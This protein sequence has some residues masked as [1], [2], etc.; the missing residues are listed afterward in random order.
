[1]N[2]HARIQ[3]SARGGGHGPPAP[4]IRACESLKPILS[5]RR[6]RARVLTAG[7]PDGAVGEGW[8]RPGRHRSPRS[9]PRPP[10]WTNQRHARTFRATAPRLTLSALPLPK[11]N[12]PR[13]L[14]ISVCFDMAGQSGSS[15][16]RKSRADRWRFLGGVWGD[17]NSA[18]HDRDS[19]SSFRKKVRPGERRIDPRE[20]QT[21]RAQPWNMAVELSGWVF[22]EA[23]RLRVPTPTLTN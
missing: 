15:A 13:V 14:Q 4:C 10:R 16:S 20:G 18:D 23:S 12:P 2:N 17:S 21:Q 6:Q 5:C 3:D 7:I 22:T 8:E 11:H 19:S 1:M 9:S